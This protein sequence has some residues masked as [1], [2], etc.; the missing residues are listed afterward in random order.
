[1]DGAPQRLEELGLQVILQ[2]GVDS[3]IVRL[4]VDLD[5]QLVLWKIPRKL[6]LVVLILQPKR[7]ASEVKLPLVVVLFVELYVHWRLLLLG[8][9]VVLGFG[10][11]LAALFECFL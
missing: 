1:M 5:R 9:G 10:A 3:G 8:Q 7:R 4:F 6:V 11:L 2:E